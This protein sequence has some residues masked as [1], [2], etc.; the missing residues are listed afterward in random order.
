MLKFFVTGSWK[1]LFFASCCF[2]VISEAHLRSISSQAT[3]GLPWLHFD[4][5]TFNADFNGWKQKLLGVFYAL[6][7]PGLR[8]DTF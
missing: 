3:L 1:E 2:G 6:L 8:C 4:V 7:Y 5:L